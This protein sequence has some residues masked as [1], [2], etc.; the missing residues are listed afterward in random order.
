MDVHP[1]RTEA[2]Y[3]AALGAVSALVNL[4]PAPSTPRGDKL[5]ILAILVERYEAEHFPMAAPSPI[6]AINFRMEQAGLQY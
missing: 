6:D 1:I 5:E 2:E 4:D 3:E